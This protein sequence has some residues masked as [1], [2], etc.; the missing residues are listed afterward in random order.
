MKTNLNESPSAMRSRMDL[1][2]CVLRA[3]L[4]S[5]DYSA[6]PRRI[7]DV[8]G[9]RVNG[10][11]A[12]MAWKLLTKSTSARSCAQVRI[13]SRCESPTAKST[14]SWTTRNR[15]RTRRYSLPF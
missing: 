3:G 15:P 12:G 2:H 8:G 4:H 7:G 10:K 14:V 13:S 5:A 6:W 1:T 11:P 9:T